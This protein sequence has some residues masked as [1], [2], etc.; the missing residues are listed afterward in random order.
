MWQK[1]VLGNRCITDTFGN[2]YVSGSIPLTNN[3]VTTGAH[4]V[5]FGGGV[6][7]GFLIKYDSSGTM[8]WGTYY[9]GSGNDT[10]SLC[11]ADK[12]ANI[13]ISG[14]TTS[15]NNISTVGS[16]QYIYQG[17]N[18]GFI[19]KFDQNGMRKWGTY[20]GGTAKDAINSLDVNNGSIAICG[21]TYSSSG[22]SISG[23]H[24][25]SLS[26]ANYNAFL[27]L[28]DTS[29]TISWSTYYG[30]DSTSANDC[31]IDDS[32]NIF[33]CGTT[34]ATINIST[35]NVHQSSNLGLSDAYLVKFNISGIRQWGT[36]YG[37]SNYDGAKQCI[38]TGGHIFVLGNTS[39]STNIAFPKY[40]SPYTNQTGFVAEFDNLGQRLTGRYIGGYSYS[41]SPN[42]YI[43]ISDVVNA[44]SNGVN[45]VYIPFNIY[46][47]IGCLT[48]VKHT[49]YLFKYS[50]C[51]SI[52]SPNITTSSTTFCQGSTVQLSTTASS[53]FFKWYR[54]D[55]A[56]TPVG[57]SNIFLASLPGK[58]N[59]LL[60]SG[61][62]V[63]FLSNA[64][65]LTEL[66][67][68]QTSVSKNDLP[69]YG[70]SI[71]AAIT[72]TASGS[73]P[74]Y[75]YNWDNSNNT[76]NSHTNLPLG[77]Y[78][79]HVTDANGCV[80]SDTTTILRTLEKQPYNSIIQKDVPCY[81]ASLGYISLSTSHG[82]PP[83]H[84]TW[85]NR[86]DTTPTISNL[87]TGV[88]Y[89]TTTDSINCI[90][91]DSIIINQETT[92]PPSTP[93]AEICAVTVDSA[94]GKNLI[95]WEK[96][97]NVRA[98]NYNIYTEGSTSG[99]YNL[100]GT[101]SVTQFS[102]YLDN[103]SNPLQQSYLYKIS[104]VDSCNYENA[105][106]N[107]HK[108]I[109][110]T[111]NLGI[112]GEVNLSWNQYEGRPYSTHYIMRSF[113]G[114]PFTLLNQVSATITSYSDLTP[115][116]GTKVYRIDVDLPT[117]CNPQK[118][119]AYNFISSN[120]VRLGDSSISHKTDIQITPNPTT[121]VITISGTKPAIVKLFNA[122][123]KLVFEK[124]ETNQLDLTQYPP[125][126][127]LI[128][129]YNEKG[130][131]YHHQKLVKN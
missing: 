48:N 24:Q 22:I 32:G 98:K 66:P 71:G 44:Y 37:G 49:S 58:Y 25:P 111:A 12:F 103:S 72:I 123:G 122:V 23:A 82:T 42:C 55:T 113:N 129:L 27:A 96:Q 69:C 41:G 61:G 76:T 36:Y 33:L 75:F 118:T 74:P 89:V 9:G 8:I 101:N 115:P 85:A 110:L 40:Y 79:S 56:L 47:K 124:K 60:D 31:I 92:T 67:L 20:Y 100:I 13:Y 35:S 11:K 39:S 54:N 88:Y 87:G 50:I 65:I 19:A 106:S 93:L 16:Y 116:T 104:E 5:A 7:D 46:E 125:A 83:Y 28:F 62:C 34:K 84:Y 117:G 119:T 126:I 81:G 68:P 105:L 14:N 80:K 4:Q 112:N 43:Y 99:Q 107:H 15:S 128:R 121:G 45:D 52:T 53:S 51:N 130:E 70:P 127:Y 120:A 10:I 108:T 18:D 97:G 77:T 91:V 78:I 2:L 59:L 64:I 30:D 3:I 73:T 17:L 63:S 90:Q 102:T 29:G 114:V 21:I 109:H 95:I 38:K 94:T 131:V 1:Q 26:G 86:P 6:S 57:A